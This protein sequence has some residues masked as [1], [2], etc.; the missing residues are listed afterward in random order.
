MRPFALALLVA[1]AALASSARAQDASADSTEAAADTTA[2]PLAASVFAFGEIADSLA[3]VRAERAERRRL[4]AEAEAEAQARRQPTVEVLG[5]S[6]ASALLPGGWEGPV[7]ISE[8]DLPAYAL[9][10]AR[11]DAMDSPLHG[12]I[13]RV[14]R[15]TGLNALYRERFSKGQTTYGYHGS[16]PVGPA[17]APEGLGL[18]LNGPGTGGAVAFVQRGAT[19]WTV[20]V[21]APLETWAA[22]RADVLAVLA[23]VRLP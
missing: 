19:M 8:V 18:E 17:A 22:H 11:N 4:A 12:A 13:L 7:T 5:T 10:T 20:A 16:S 15:V 6:G 3:V 2:A 9:Y 23:G 1:S 14:E 21:E